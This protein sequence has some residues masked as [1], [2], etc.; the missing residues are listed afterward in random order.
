MLERMYDKPDAIP[1]LLQEYRD[2][3]GQLGTW[4]MTSRRQPLQ[5]DFLVVASQSRKCPGPSPLSGKSWS[6]K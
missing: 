4:I 6:T 2:A 3:I 1:N 5:I